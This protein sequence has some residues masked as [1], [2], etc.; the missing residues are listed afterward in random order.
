MQTKTHK[1]K[2]YDTAA[3]PQSK[4]ERKQEVLTVQVDLAMENLRSVIRSYGYN[5]RDLLYKFRRISGQC[6]MEYGWHLDDVAFETAMRLFGLTAKSSVIQEIFQRHQTDVECGHRVTWSDFYKMTLATPVHVDTPDGY[7]IS[8]ITDVEGNMDYFKSLVS[9]DTVIQ[10]SSSNTLEFTEKNGYFVYGGDTVDNGCHDLEFLRQLIA[11][12]RSY[13][14]RVFLLMGNRDINKLRLYKELHYNPNNTKDLP[15]IRSVSQ[16]CYWDASVFNPK[17]DA[18]NR[19]VNPGECSYHAFLENAPDEKGVRHIPGGKL[20]HNWVSILKWTLSRTMGA[21][22]VFEYRREELRAS[23]KGKNHNREISDEDVYHSFY[24]SCTPAPKGKHKKRPKRKDGLM[25]QYLKLA[26]IGCKIGDAAFIH[27]ALTDENVGRCP[28][29]P[30]DFR[31]QGVDISVWFAH[32]NQWAKKRIDSFCADPEHAFIGDLLDY[33]LPIDRKGL[34]CHSNPRHSVIT[35]TWLENGNNKHLS[36]YLNNWLE[37]AHKGFIVTGQSPHG[38]CPSII[39]GPHNIVVMCDTSYSDKPHA[40]RTAY[41]NVTIVSA[42]PSDDNDNEISRHYARLHVD[43]VLSSENTIFRSD[44]DA[45]HSPEDRKHGFV[46]SIHEKMSADVVSHADGAAT[47]DQLADQLIGQELE[48][49]YWVSSQLP[50]QDMLLVKF[51]DSHPQSMSMSVNN[52]SLMQYAQMQTGVGDESK[53]DSQPNLEFPEAYRT[54]LETVTA[55]V[56]VADMPDLQ[57]WTDS[58]YTVTDELLPYLNIWYILEQ[59]INVSGIFRKDMNPYAEK[60]KKM[61]FLK[62]LATTSLKSGKQAIDAID[63]CISDWD[64][65]TIQFIASQ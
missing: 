5:K 56:T 36:S 49:G 46:L 17:M 33:A 7:A 52:F 16:R 6:K 55:S 62:W 50:N 39:R 60:S 23:N 57:Y 48:D 38:D 18:D 13:P 41:T 59:W 51:A 35:S 29:M 64:F 32:L 22:N 63:A 9:A 34:P 14:D 37:E 40:N 44:D 53:I 65:E 45:V 19:E 27:G 12:K 10:Y 3:S 31:I 43:G 8:F 61:L 26:V 30:H 47:N 15:D 2:K 25:V 28:D 20:V 1:K 58:G 11:F 21:P 42:T 4:Q 54:P 24:K